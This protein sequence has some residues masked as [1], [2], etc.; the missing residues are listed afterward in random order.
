MSENRESEVEVDPYEEIVGPNL[1]TN[2]Q[3]SLESSF[4]WQK[5]IKNDSLQRTR[6]KMQ[7][8]WSS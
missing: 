1:H 4:P 6:S 7:W 8:K 3:S 5:W 2:G